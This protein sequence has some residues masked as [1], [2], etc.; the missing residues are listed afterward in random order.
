MGAR[1][2]WDSS[3]FGAQ[4]ITAAPA[5]VTYSAQMVFTDDPNLGPSGG[6]VVQNPYN[7]AT[8]IS[9]VANGV[10]PGFYTQNWPVNSVAKSVS[11]SA[12][13]KSTALGIGLLQV[14]PWDGLG[15]VT[16]YP[17]IATIQV[18]TLS[19]SSQQ[20]TFQDEL[21]FTYLDPTVATWKLTYYP[22]DEYFTAGMLYYFT[23]KLYYR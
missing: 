15:V 9:Y 7:P 8:L 19:V 11:L 3:P 12:I 5:G 22:I 20:T 16:N 6:S 17:S 2:N 10:G 1:A 14:I 4:T 18:S 13:A 23:S 21:A